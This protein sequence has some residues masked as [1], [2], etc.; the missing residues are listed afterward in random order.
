[1]KGADYSGARPTVSQLKANG[2][3]FV[4][5]YLAPQNSA[6]S[7]KLLT[8]N[9]ANTLRAGGIQV[10]SNFEWYESRC[11]EGYAAGQADARTAAAYHLGCGGPKD[12]PIYF[13]VDTDT[14]GVNVKAYFQGVASIIGLSRT[15]VY[16]SYRVCKYLADNKL[17]GVTL[18]GAK[19]NWQTYAWSYG[20]YDERS[21]LSQD[22]NG[23]KLAGW[24]VDI[25]HSHT[26]DY[27][28]W[29]Y[30]HEEDDGLA[31]ISQAD[32]NKLMS[33]YLGTADGKRKVAEAVILTT[34]LIEANQKVDAAGKP[35]VD[36]DGNPVYEK[37]SLRAIASS[38][39][40][41]VT[42][43]TVPDAQ[44][45]AEGVKALAEKPA[46]EV[47]LSPELVQ[48]VKD[49]VAAALSPTALYNA[50]DQATKDVTVEVKR[51]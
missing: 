35:A 30:V 34:G 29:D 28:Q 23:V 43:H 12:R 19:L 5:R 39:R 6:T 9:E 22:Q 26:A 46:A 32:F 38:T 49:A 45:A 36:K 48:A 10:V 3:K 15:G 25:D 11:T 14:S 27:G 50:V 24:D 13:S 51:A 42:E 31:N 41:W 2:V 7:W 1:M 20:S 44:A 17:V 47:A 16:G 8:W 33:G 4:L 37:W 40:G 18:S 21:A